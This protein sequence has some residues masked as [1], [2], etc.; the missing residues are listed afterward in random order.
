LGAGEERDVPVVIW[1]SVAAMSVLGVIGLLASAVATPHDEDFDLHL[2]VGTRDAY[3]KRIQNIPED[4]RT[5]WRFHVVRPGESLDSLA[6][7]FHDR[8]TEIAAANNL[9]ASAPVDTGAELVIPVAAV[10]A[11]PHQLHYVTRAGDTLVTI[12]DRFNVSV[13]DLRRW[14]Q[15]SSAAIKPH[16]TLA[17]AQPVHLAP[18]THAQATRSHTTSRPTTKTAATSSKAKSTAKPAAKAPSTSAAARKT[19]HA[20]QHP[21]SN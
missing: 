18:A 6:S 4:K 14:N 17:V 12:A 11:T 2:P 19:T 8:P 21:A 3:L 15:L 1:T 5:S 10:V 20:K 13:E 9:E 7:N 16:R